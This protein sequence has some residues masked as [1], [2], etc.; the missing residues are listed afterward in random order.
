[1]RLVGIVIALAACGGS[2]AGVVEPVTPPSKTPAAAPSTASTTGDTQTTDDTT[3]V[4]W[5]TDETDDGSKPRARSTVGGRVSNSDFDPPATAPGD[6]AKTSVPA[7]AHHTSLGASQPSTI[8]TDLDRSGINR[9]IRV[10]FSELRA[11]FEAERQRDPDARLGDIVSVT[12]WIAP[13]G[14]VAS[15]QAH[16]IGRALEAC[17]AD[18]FGK[19]SFFSHSANAGDVEVNYPLRIEWAAN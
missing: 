11:C 13:N 10:H 6:T 2:Q 9:V 15:A 18:A 8:S 12:F 19:M 3:Q 5:G 4:P 7:R 14:A 17:V 1:M 16:G